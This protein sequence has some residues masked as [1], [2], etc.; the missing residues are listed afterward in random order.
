MARRLVGAPAAHRIATGR[1]HRLRGPGPA[2]SG[3]PSGLA[4]GWLKRAVNLIFNR[5]LQLASS[6]ATLAAGGDFPAR[7]RASP[8]LLPRARARRFGLAARLMV[9]HDFRAG[10]PASTRRASSCCSTSRIARAWGPGRR[11]PRASRCWERRLFALGPAGARDPAGR[12]R[13]LGASSPIHPRPVPPPPGPPC[14][15]PTPARG[16]CRHPPP[17]AKH[18]AR[19]CGSRLLFGCQRSDTP[20]PPPSHTT[21]CDAA[22]SAGTSVPTATAAREARWA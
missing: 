14:S 21:D 15:E 8:R 20:A 6:G 16:S 2:G 13:G 4:L 5:G 18:V 22:C 7:G 11:S 19:G 1:G 3:C 17:D 9:L 10:T 12:D